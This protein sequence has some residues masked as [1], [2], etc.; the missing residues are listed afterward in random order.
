[1]GRFFYL[2]SAHLPPGSCGFFY[3][4]HDKNSPPLAGGVRFRLTRT[5]HP[6]DF[7]SG[8]DLILNGLPWVLPSFFV[9]KRPALKHLKAIA[10]RD[11]FFS[12][13]EVAAADAMDTTYHYRHLLTLRLV[14]SFGQPFHVDL[15][16]DMP[17]ITF[18]GKDGL[19]NPCLNV[20]FGI[21]A[22]D[23]TK[24]KAHPLYEGEPCR[25]NG[26]PLSLSLTGLAR[27]SP[28]RRE[29]ALRV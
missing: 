21:R 15:T 1:M 17:R 28:F 24:E 20:A 7:A 25:P 23:G 5:P 12:E 2:P 18:I 14:H 3:Y 6:A 29:A 19:K 16:T 27:G 22:R 13:D 11:G 4:H 26:P 9:L 8:T 10:I